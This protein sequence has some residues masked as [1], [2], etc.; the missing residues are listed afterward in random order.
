HSFA[1]R[2]GPSAPTAFRRQWSSDRVPGEDFARA[3]ERRQRGPEGA[4]ELLGDLAR[5][6]AVGAVHHPDRTRLVEQEYLIVAHGENLSG[7]SLGR[8]GA[9]IDRKRG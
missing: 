4:F 3:L 2:A 7:N 5:C 8:I 1:R 9:E 6:P